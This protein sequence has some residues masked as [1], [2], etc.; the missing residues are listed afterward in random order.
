MTE[1]QARK[2]NEFANALFAVAELAKSAPSGGWDYPIPYIIANCRRWAKIYWVK[3]W[4][5]ATPAPAA[6]ITQ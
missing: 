3:G 1:E 5:P 4:E 2:R 6:S